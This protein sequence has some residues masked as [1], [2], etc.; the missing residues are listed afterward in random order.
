MNYKIRR[1]PKT[2]SW[3]ESRDISVGSDNCISC[4]EET[5][6]PTD[7]QMLEF[8]KSKGQF[9]HEYMWPSRTEPGCQP[10]GWSW[11][12]SQHHEGWLCFDCTQRVNYI[13]TQGKR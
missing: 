10:V 2:I 5:P 1:K 9:F 11:Y 6:Y 3:K 12:K 8:A 4:G 7:E 13:I